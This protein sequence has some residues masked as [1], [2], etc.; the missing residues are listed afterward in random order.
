[1]TE[2][3]TFKP[4]DMTSYPRAEYG[5]Y[6]DV[7]V[8]IPRDVAVQ[9]FVNMSRLGLRFPSDLDR[10]LELTSLSDESMGGGGCDV[11]K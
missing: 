1:M 5:A 10:Y 9:V 3:I 6:E 8:E 11:C 7:I 4:K 2:K